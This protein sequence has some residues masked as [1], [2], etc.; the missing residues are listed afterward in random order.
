MYPLNMKLE[1]GV[2]FAVANDEAEHLALTALGYGPGLTIVEADPAEADVAGH[3]VASVRAA[4][5][6][7]G[8]AYDKR[9]GLAKLLELIPA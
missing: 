4:L 5:D 2:G 7:A 1:Q 3:T 8:I 9:L 6:S